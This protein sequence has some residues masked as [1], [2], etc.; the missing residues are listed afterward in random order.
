MKKLLW[1]ALILFGLLLVAALWQFNGARTM[2]DPQTLASLVSDEIIYDDNGLVDYVAM[3][4]TRLSRDLRPEDNAFIDYARIL[5]PANLSTGESSE[6]CKLLK[7][8]SISNNDLFVTMEEM[9]AKPITPGDPQ[10]PRTQI[11]Q[12]PWT[13]EEFPDCAQWLERNARQ[14]EAI[15]AAAR[16]PKYYYPFISTIKLG[17]KGWRTSSCSL[18]HVQQ[19]RELARFLTTHAMN[20]TVRGDTSA[21]VNDLETIHRMAAHVSQGLCT[22]EKLVGIAFE[23]LAFLAASH[24]LA[25]ENITLEQLADYRKY[26]RAHDLDLR[27]AESI[28]ISE[29]YMALDAVQSVEKWG[30]GV[31]SNAGGANSATSNTVPT[32]I[33]SALD[34]SIVANQLSANIDSI[35]ESLKQPDDL[36]RLR[37]LQSFETELQELP[38][39]ALGLGRFFLGPK[40]RA[41]AVGKIL[42]ALLMPAA[43]VIAAAE[44][45]ARMQRE[46]LDLGL[47]IAEYRLENGRLPESLDVLVPKYI[48]VVPLDRFTQKPL[49]YRVYDDGFEL[50]SVGKDGE[51]NDDAPPESFKDIRFIARPYKPTAANPVPNQ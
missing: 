19:M 4:N 17:D 47:A 35:V 44:I 24:V 36:V 26:L 2:N 32:Q 11:T 46:M 20:A 41:E 34:W 16:K 6:L 31:L 37:E 28:S 51:L 1:A 9:G 45:R 38:S 22:V 18:E 27:L 42:S 3:L 30:V 49:I 7:I 13:Q 12:R 5:L 8:D 50:I 33:W 10:D 40:A 39:N 21:A 23:G 14:I 43:Q 15:H 25:N 48:A 29:R